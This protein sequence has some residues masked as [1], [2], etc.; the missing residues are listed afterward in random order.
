MTISAGMKTREIDALE[1]ALGYHFIRRAV[2]EQALT[3]SRSRSRQA[4]ASSG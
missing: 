1:S 3:H 4:K 2:I